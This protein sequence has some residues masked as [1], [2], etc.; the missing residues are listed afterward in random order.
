VSKLRIMKASHQ[1]Q[2][3]QMQ[4]RLLKYFPEKI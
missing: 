2:Q 4:D 3:F 1:S